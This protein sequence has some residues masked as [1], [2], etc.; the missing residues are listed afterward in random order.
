MDLTRYFENPFDNTR[1]SEN[2]FLQGV[3]FHLVSLQVSNQGGIYDTIL[4]QSTPLYD[5]LRNIASARLSEFAQQQGSTVH[6][7]QTKNA[8]LRLV[9]ISEGLIRSTF[10]GTDTPQYQEFFPRGL[11]ELN[12]ATKHQL[13]IISQ[14]LVHYASIYLA[15]LGPQLH[16]DFEAARQAMMSARAAQS[17]NIAETSVLRHRTRAARKAMAEQ[18]LRNL[19]TIG[20][21][22]TGKPEVVSQFFDLNLFR[23]PRRKKKKEGEVEG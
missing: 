22:N 17:T 1:I 15:Q 7:N 21:H 9:M 5:A 20:L 12:R 2:D 4:A 10:G 14:R 3:Q 18:L 23:G 6:A 16:A 11:T 13:D 8:F 19:Y